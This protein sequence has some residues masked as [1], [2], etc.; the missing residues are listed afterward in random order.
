MPRADKW[1]VADDLDLKM[2]IGGKRIEAANGARIETED[3][4]TGRVE[5]VEPWL[6]RDADPVEV[7]PAGFAARS[8]VA[9]AKA[10]LLAHCGHGAEPLSDADSHGLTIHR[11]REV[12]HARVDLLA[13]VRLE[14]PD[15]EES[16]ASAAI[17]FPVTPE[18]AFG[19][20]AREEDAAGRAEDLRHTGVGTVLTGRMIADGRV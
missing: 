20:E 15:L 14:V 17:V 16:L 8:R 2:V 6:D 1:S 3:P 10:R 9:V 7:H 11:E 5:I 18:T 4:A 12:R 19:G 13:L